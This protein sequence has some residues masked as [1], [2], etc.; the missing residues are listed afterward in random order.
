MS[1]RR[2]GRYRK[3]EVRTWG[4]DKFRKL[5]KIP[6]CGQGLWLF[7]LTGPHTGVIPGLFRAGRASMAEELGWPLEAFDQAFG[8]A[9][10][11]GMVKADFDAR[12]VWLPN[13]VKHNRPESLN[14]VK[15]WGSEF[16]SLPEC[17]LK[18]E[19]YNAFGSMIC[20]MG[21]SFRKAF[22]KA[23]AKPSGKPSPMPIFEFLSG[24]GTGTGAGTGEKEGASAPASFHEELNLSPVFITLTLK[25]GQQHE[26]REALVVELEKQY[27][28]VDV[29]RAFARMKAYFAKPSSKRKTKVGIRRCIETWLTKDQDDGTTPRNGATGHG[30]AAEPAK[31]AWGE[32]MKAL[33]AGRP[34]ATWTHPQTPAALDAIGGWANLKSVSEREL[35]FKRAQFLAAFNAGAH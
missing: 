12:L 21:D 6:P 35:G 31:E 34:P 17:A 23:W 29:R 13:S 20:G 1:D 33:S 32:F 30:Q 16:D 24:A 11:H 5:T 18:V 14:V 27:P 4:D 25:N 2:G 9:L 15:C 28:D 10:A 22:V 19:A 3:V 7:L 8:E 26:I